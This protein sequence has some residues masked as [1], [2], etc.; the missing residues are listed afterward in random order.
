MP[1]PRIRNRI[2]RALHERGWTDQVLATKAS[3]SRS[4]VNEIKNC[5]AQP[6]V[7]EGLAI[8]RSLDLSIAELFYF[9]REPDHLKAR[10][11]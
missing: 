3:I 9:E 1:V 10:G 6:T 8:S 4:R 11:L 7:A 2:S 5:V